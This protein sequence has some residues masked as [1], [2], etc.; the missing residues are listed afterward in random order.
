MSNSKQFG[1]TSITIE[2]FK[3]IGEKVTI[4]LKPITL[5]FGANSAGKST[6]L[7]VLA[8]FQEAI[9]TWRHPEH[10]SFS[11]HLIEFGSFKSVVHR[12]EENRSVKISIDIARPA[13]G[14]NDSGKKQPRSWADTI[15]KMFPGVAA[16]SYQ[17]QLEVRSDGAA[18]VK[19]SLNNEQIIWVD[20]QS[21]ELSRDSS[22]VKKYFLKWE[23]RGEEDW[24]SEEELSNADLEFWLTREGPID[25]SRPWVS[26]SCEVGPWGEVDD[27]ETEAAAQVAYE[28]CAVLFCPLNQYLQQQRYIGPLRQI[29][30]RH[31]R[32]EDVPAGDWYSGM[33]A[34]RELDK[35]LKKEPPYHK[36]LFNESPEAVAKLALQEIG[37]LKLGYRPALKTVLSVER[38]QEEIPAFGSKQIDPM[39]ELNELVQDGKVPKRS[40]SL[41]L[42]SEDGV[43]VP[44]CDV[45]TGVS[46]ALPIAVGAFSEGCR[47]MMVEQPELHLH[48]RLQCDL[49]DVFVSNIHRHSDR[50][51][52]IETH[53]EHLILR[54]LRRIR[55][56]S[57]GE[58]D[59]S[60]LALTPDDVGVLYVDETDNGVQIKE[61]PITPD[62]DFAEKWPQGFFVE[63]AEELF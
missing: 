25:F 27:G 46:Q 18:K 11:G 48:P 6:I 30:G 1:I 14:E 44:P 45:G 10:V 37:N 3:G 26:Y 4:P 41:I 40:Q 28:L 42:L 19:I 60:N 39:G 33:A 34:W 13:W 51:F 9:K 59:D 47:L 43:P 63:R 55:E 15:E 53:S 22:I 16:E 32:F 56:T 54:L 7:K 21:I 58:L 24:F 12:H 61:L 20:G 2:N 52:I 29:P 49:A 5:L 35:I 17:L 8:Y 23:R 36:E 31:Q 50:K 57:E 62:G 38:I